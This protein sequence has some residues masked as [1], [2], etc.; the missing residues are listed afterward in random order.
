MRRRRAVNTRL[1][2]ATKSN[3]MKRFSGLGVVAP[4]ALAATLFGAVAVAQQSSSQALPPNARELARQHMEAAKKAAGYE[5]SD[6]YDHTCTRLM[7]GAGMP[8][9]RIVPP[10][11]DR[12]PKRFHEEPV[13]VFDNLYYVGEKMQHGGSPSAWAVITSQGIILIDAMF[14]DSV[15]DEVVNGLKKVNLDPANIKDIILTHGHVD[16]YGGA[17]FLQDTY[18]PHVLMGAPD[19]EALSSGRGGAGR[20]PKP[21]RDISVVD[22]QKLTLGDETIT[23]H[24]TPGHTPG[25]LALL[26]PVTDHGTPHLAAMWG[27]T[28]MQYS[29]EEYNKSALR[30]RDIV[31]KAGADIILSTHSQLDK[32]DIKL[33][34]VEKRKG[35]DPNPYVVGAQVVQNYL[36]VAAECSAAAM[37]LPDEY[38]GYLG[39]GGNGARG[40]SAPAQTGKGGGR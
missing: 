37:L 34:L 3:G 5:V 35:G 18:H 6:L 26:I 25:T 40:G 24:L 27:G 14:A 33:R 7:I 32:S 31:M 29:A 38:Q 22:G 2:Q 21:A 11:N 13:K 28:G 10:E 17:A 20:G 12:D 16:H 4:F 23:M 39:R 19:W 30:F 8:F 15:Q 9:G 1:N 36:T